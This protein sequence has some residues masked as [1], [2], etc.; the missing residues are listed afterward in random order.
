MST[1][2]TS[3][4]SRAEIAKR[5]ARADR[6]GYEPMLELGS[7]AVEFSTN[8]DTFAARVAHGLRTRMIYRTD[9]GRL[10]RG[11]VRYSGDLQAIHARNLRRNRADRMDTI[12]L[13]VTFV[14][15]RSNIPTERAVFGIRFAENLTTFDTTPV[16][17]SPETRKKNR[18]A[19][20]EAFLA[21]AIIVS[22]DMGCKG[23]RV[24]A[25]L[26][27][28]VKIGYPRNEKLWFYDP[29][30]VYEY[31]H[32]LSDKERAQMP[33]AVPQAKGAYGLPLQVYPFKGRLRTRRP[34]APLY[35]QKFPVKD[36][37]Y[38]ANANDHT[39]RRELAALYNDVQE[40]TAIV[41][42]AL[43][44]SQ[45]T[46]P[47]SKYVGEFGKHLAK[48]VAGKGRHEHGEESVYHFFEPTC[49]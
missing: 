16:D 37:A 48:L 1:N 38:L 42:R 24:R 31:V 17:P 25:M 9:N 20:A 13:D 45:A 23:D 8:F 3:Y 15:R 33:S 4:A 26:E 32:N 49:H 27:Y 21:K 19:R 5:V 46:L 43:G 30:T 47:P 41:E 36:M 10:A 22:M 18:K 12:V 2:P 44:L 40:S 14:R 34:V 11:M 28:A 6:E 7:L 29:R 35:W 39:M